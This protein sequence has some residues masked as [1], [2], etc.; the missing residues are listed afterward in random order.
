[1]RLPCEGHERPGAVV[2][3][4]HRAFQH[5]RPARQTLA[6]RGSR[7]FPPRLTDRNIV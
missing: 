5:A 4:S 6:P 7:K 1:V 3:V 2:G